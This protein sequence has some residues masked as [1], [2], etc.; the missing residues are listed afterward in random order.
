MQFL[1]TKYRKIQ[2]YYKTILKKAA[3]CMYLYVVREWETIIFSWI[4]EDVTLELSGQ[5]WKKYW[6]HLEARA[7]CIS[8]KKKKK[9]SLPGNPEKW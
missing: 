4:T 2:W 8:I 6:R 9:K 3:K 1:T 5:T 7:D